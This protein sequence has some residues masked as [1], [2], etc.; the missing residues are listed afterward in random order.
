MLPDGPWPSGELLSAASV[1]EADRRLEPSG[2][3]GGDVCVLKLHAVQLVQAL[4]RRLRLRQRAVAT[5][6]VYLRRFFFVHT[7]LD[8]DSLL[9]APTCVWVSSKAE[10][11]ALSAKMVVSELHQLEPSAPY[12]HAD[13][14]AAEPLLLEALDFELPVSHPFEHVSRYLRAAGVQSR[15]DAVRGERLVETAWCLAGHTWRTPTP[16]TFQ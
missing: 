6:M 14:A 12:T 16:C 15:V 3:S 11:C 8:H 1:A 4:G 9:I 5:A 13:L 2:F 7:L 10:E